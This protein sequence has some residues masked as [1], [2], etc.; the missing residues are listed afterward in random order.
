MPLL[1]NLRHLEA[2][3]LQLKGQ[4]PARVLDF[5]MRDEMVRADDPLHYDFEVQKVEQGLL[6]HGS[7][8]LTLQCQCVRCLKPFEHKIVL[9]DW[10]RHLPLEGEER[11]PV[12]SDCVDLTP[13]VREDILLEF[14]QHPLCNSD[15]CGLP[16]AVGGKALKSGD[17]GQKEVKSSAWAALD[18]LKF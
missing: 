10:T 6:A 14:P 5:D 1:V 3:N 4:V 11:T 13:Y 9:N 2:H 8:R 12:A 15:S 16:K 18:K 17:P 7:L